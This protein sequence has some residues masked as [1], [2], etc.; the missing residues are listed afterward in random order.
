MAGSNFF[1]GVMAKRTLLRKYVRMKLDPKTQ[2]SAKRAQ[3]LDVRFHSP[4]STT[5]L[6][7]PKLFITFW[8][9]RFSQRSSVL[10]WIIRTAVGDQSLKSPPGYA[11]FASA[12]FK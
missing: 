9:S 11:C 2:S 6:V 12:P 1:D 3:T 7:E 5:E 10:W 4:P 8:L